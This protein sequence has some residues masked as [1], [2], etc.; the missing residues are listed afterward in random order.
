MDESDGLSA[1]ALAALL[2]LKR[3]KDKGR[4]I[5]RVKTIMARFRWGKDKW[6]RVRRELIA[7]GA[8]RSHVVRDP[9]SG[10]IVRNWVTVSWPKNRGPE[11]PVAGLDREPENPAP[12]PDNPALV[13]RKTRLLNKQKK[14]GGAPR[15][16]AGGAPP[17]ANKA[18][19]VVLSDEQF[20]RWH[21]EA[22][23]QETR[24]DWLRRVGE[25]A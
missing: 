23:P 2:F 14:R 1:D 17:R 6:Q 16:K 19:S 13:G 24:A 5:F 3:Q 18:E 21:R 12:G 15:P 11:N 22:L 10:K 4:E 7:A 8:F 9:E 20:D 25:D